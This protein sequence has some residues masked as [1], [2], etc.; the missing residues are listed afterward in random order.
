MQRKF[1]KA[2]DKVKV[3]VRFRGREM[4]HSNV[5]GKRY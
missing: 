4:E 3:T 5:V 1:L 2:E